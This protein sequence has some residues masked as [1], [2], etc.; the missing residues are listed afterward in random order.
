VDH[1]KSQHRLPVAEPLPV[2]RFSLYGEPLQELDETFV[3]VE[4]IAYRSR[5]YQWRI[6]A[7]IHSDLDQL[8]FI[9][10]GSGTMQVD[11]QE[12][13]IRAPAVL[14]APATV[15]HGFQFARGTRGF[16]VTA[17]QPLIRALQTREPELRRV[18]ASP[19]CIGLSTPVAAAADLETLIDRL[20]RETVWDAPA[21]RLAAEAWLAAVMIATLRL[22]PEEPCGGSL[23]R[24]P[25]ATLV[26]RFRD[27]L[28]ERCRS[29]WSVARYARQ[30]AVSPGKLRAAC[31]AIS[32]KPPRQLLH[33][34]V[35]LEARRALTYT[36]L[37]VA[38]TAYQ[39]GF[40]DP[41]YFSRFFSTHAGESPQAFRLRTA[42]P[43]GA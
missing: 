32:G 21:N 12:L 37:T 41:G 10:H 33:E 13:P 16:V 31:L 30:L 1:S 29:G 24:G 28:D 34:R 2:P 6:R 3:H 40:S 11:G 17:A 20:R 39:L 14:L 35:L 26:D 15:V 23:R 42:K 38:Q 5:R 22:L 43:Q 27:L 25:V 8:L 19:A 9:R 4:T 18:F 36:D 7:H